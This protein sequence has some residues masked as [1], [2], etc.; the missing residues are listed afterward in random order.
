[1]YKWV[2]FNNYQRYGY[3]ALYTFK[4]GTGGQHQY[5]HIVELTVRHTAVYTAIHHKKYKPAIRRFIGCATCL[6]TDSEM[7]SSVSVLFVGR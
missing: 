5:V 7:E 3:T 1:M 2:L 6:P 4:F